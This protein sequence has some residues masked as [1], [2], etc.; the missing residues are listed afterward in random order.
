VYWTILNQ[1]R[2]FDVPT[3]VAVDVFDDPY[4]MA[5]RQTS[6]QYNG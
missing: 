6:R 3:S 1:D 5:N 2:S 4:L